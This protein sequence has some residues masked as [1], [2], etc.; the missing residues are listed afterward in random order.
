MF[1]RVSSLFALALC[2]LHVSAGRL[3]PIASLLVSL[4]LST[5][6]PGFVEVRQIG[7]L[8]CNIDRGEIV[9][10]ILAMQGT[11]KTLASQLS[12]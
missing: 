11:L 9:A 12:S 7:N 8:Q 10:D 1:F 4:N 3:L 2:A 5:S 6:A